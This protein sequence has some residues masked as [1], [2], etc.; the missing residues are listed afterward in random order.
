M[1]QQTYERPNTLDEA[2]QLLSEHAGRAAILNGGT[3]LLVQLHDGLL[4]VD[5]IID[6]KGIDS[7]HHIKVSGNNVFIG[8]CATMNAISSHK[9]LSARVPF[10]CE[11]AH[12]VGSNQVRNKATSI[13]NL[14]NASPLADTA[15]PLLVLD[16][17]VHI[18]SQSGE[19]EVPLSD[20]FVFVRKTILEPHEIVTGVSFE[21]P[22][23]IEG[24]FTKT[25]RRAVGD[26]S[27]VCSTIARV[28]SEY[29][30]A[31][32]SV[33]PTPIRLI[34]TEAFLKEHGNTETTRDEAV[35][36]AKQEIAPISD[37]RGS[38]DFRAYTVGLTLKRNLAALVR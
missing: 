6:I 23:D 12:H 15:T 14:V 29:R 9:V 8:A 18:F 5:M 32:G 27:T 28:H 34:R 3:D 19:R 13:G 16:A 36:I 25:S 11:A 37:I 4:D 20:F 38:K 22:D 17:K 10:L 33:A 31:F 24:I 21:I 26:L 35:V 7:L 1:L 2:T 30:I